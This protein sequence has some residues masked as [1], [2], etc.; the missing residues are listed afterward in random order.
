MLEKAVLAIVCSVSKLILAY[1]Y[2]LPASKSTSLH[3]SPAELQQTTINDVKAMLHEYFISASQCKIKGISGFYFSLQ[4][5][6]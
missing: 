4:N 5:I 2:V 1:F 6:L 3:T